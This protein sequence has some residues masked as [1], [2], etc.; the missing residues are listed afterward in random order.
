MMAAVLAG[1]VFLVPAGAPAEDRSAE[2]S[3]RAGGME[4]RPLS[5][6]D[7]VRREKPA[8]VNISTTQVVRDDVHQD[9]FTPFGSPAPNP[10]PKGF[11][12]Q[13]LG[14]GFLISREGLILTNHHVI[15][16][17]ERIIVRLNDERE[18]T[19]EVIGRD[20]KTDLALIRIR[21]EGDFPVVP[22]GDSSDL[23]VGDWVLAIGN[24]F[25]LEHTVTAGIVSAKGRV[26]GSGPYDDFIQTDASINP[27]N[28]GGPL[29]NTRGEVVGINTAINASGQG[30]GF[31]IPINMAKTLLP[32][33][34]E[35]GKVTRGWL[36]VMIQDVTDDLAH[37]FGMKEKS[38]A[39]VADVTE[40]GP[41][42]EGGVRRGDVIV[43]FDGKKIQRMK[44]L[45]LVVAESPV[46]KQVALTF[47][48]DGRNETVEVRVG[49]L[50]DED[51]EAHLGSE[52]TA[53]LGMIVEDL[54]EENFEGEGIYGVYVYRVEEE[55]AAFDAGF[56]EGD[57]ITEVDRK[58]VRDL[59]TYRQ[60]L[61]D[62]KPGEILL[63]LVKRGE[64]SLFL[65]VKIP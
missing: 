14:S 45:P 62:K 48:R 52:E 42:D 6:A 26:I 65:T 23:E 32:Q 37:S 44:D 4:S 3:V 19:A 33:L 29:F 7:L 1:I 50:M 53:E 57:V 61:R 46:G 31:A 54:P 2:S 63:F 27:G 35:S 60:K 34:Q 55:G 5:F 12:T 56:R 43:A 41:A 64:R 40:G 39:L 25:G 10:L 38:G 9:L 13:S 49:K 58:S 28:S 24:P 47:I 18:F 59:R 17:A 11:R 15:E 8:V 16:N 20:H 51:Q 36:G 22:L 30:I 21:G